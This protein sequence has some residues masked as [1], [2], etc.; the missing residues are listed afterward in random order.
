MP[1]TLISIV[2]GIALLGLLAVMAAPS[3]NAVQSM[4]LEESARQAKSLLQLAQARSAETGITHGVRFDPGVPAFEL[5]SVDL[6]TTPVTVLGVVS[7]PVSK[8]PAGVNLPAGVSVAAG[9]PFF[10]SQ[11]GGANEVYFD[12]WGT[13]V[14]RATSI[15]QLTNAAIRFEYGVQSATVVVA[16][17][18]GRVG[19]I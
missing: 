3:G 11:I 9:K 18:T 19:V 1:T 10:F 15:V 13:P 14:N 5:I 16:P 6:S 12:S 17:L 7:D 8:Q 2:A 4:W